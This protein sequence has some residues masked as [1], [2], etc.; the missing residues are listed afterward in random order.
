MGIL[1][2]YCIGIHC[3][4]FSAF[5]IVTTKTFGRSNQH[6]D[7]LLIRGRSPREG[8]VRLRGLPNTRQT[9]TTHAGHGEA[10]GNGASESEGVVEDGREHYPRAGRVDGR[11]SS[12]LFVHVDD[13]WWAL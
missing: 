11:F 2:L 6:I 7:P 8:P 10:T 3:I 9:H 13:R 5:E 1:W 4:F 12:V